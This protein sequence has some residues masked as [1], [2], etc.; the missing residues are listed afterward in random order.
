LGVVWFWKIGASC[1]RAA[2]RGTGPVEVGLVQAH[3]F[4]FAMTTEGNKEM[5]EDRARVDKGGPQIITTTCTRVLQGDDQLWYEFGVGTSLS[6][7]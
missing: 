7:D 4:S 1:D 3:D 2:L 6:T 5:H